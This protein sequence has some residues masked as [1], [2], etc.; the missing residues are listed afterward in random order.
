MIPPEINE[1]RGLEN[2]KQQ[3]REMGPLTV[4]EKK[5][6]I[7]FAA[8]LL[9]WFTQPFHK[10]DIFLISLVAA[11][12]FFLPGIN[13]LQWN[14]VKD[15]ISWEVLFLIG[16]A[17]VIA[18][19]LFNTKGAEWLAV[20]TLSGIAGMMAFM[21]LLMV[22]IF[23]IYS[24]FL[25][26]VGT[27]TASVMV[28]ILAVMTTKFGL[29]PVLMIIPVGF[30]ANCNFLVPV[31]PVPLTTY[32]YGYWKMIDMMKPAFVISTVWIPVIAVCLYFFRQVGII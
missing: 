16:G 32:H 2:V 29:D 13:V 30:T 9:L 15:K 17:N 31:D 23:G 5:Y 22:C 7:I 19:M 10:Q 24:H 8:M 21:A 3:M 12:F 26:P 11:A 27:A 20:T 4:R 1:V 14:K 28:P 18:M 25:V 6:L